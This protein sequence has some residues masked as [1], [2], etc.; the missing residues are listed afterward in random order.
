LDSLVRIEIFQLV[1]RD[2]AREF[3]RRA[4]SWQ[5][6]QAAALEAIGKRWFAHAGRVIEIPIFR[7]HL[8]ALQP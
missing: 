3:F 6:K 2:L 1:T 8:S 5:S 7:N 4:F